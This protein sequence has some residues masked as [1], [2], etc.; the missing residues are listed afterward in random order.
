[1]NSVSTLRSALAAVALSL[2]LAGFAGGHS[3]TKDL[4]QVTVK[5]DGKEVVITRNQE[6]RACPPFCV[7]PIQIAPGVETLGELE[8][9]SYLKRMSD[10]DDSIL[11]VDSRTPEWLAR[12]T[13]PGSINVPWT[14]IS[15]ES[16]TAW[17]TNAADTFREEIAKFGVADHKGMLDFSG[18]KTLVL[19]CNG[20]WCAQ[21]ATNVKTLLKHGYPADKLKWY[22]GGMQSWTDLGLTVAK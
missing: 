20:A 6:H 11:V 10:G 19:F 13:I 9:L 5:Q 22:R 21:S 7:Q 12:G 1:M 2:P 8:V 15:A 17:D 4:D 16:A 3:I 14:R 18:A